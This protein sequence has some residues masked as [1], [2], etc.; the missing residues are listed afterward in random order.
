MRISKVRLSEKMIISRAVLFTQPSHISPYSN[1]IWIKFKDG[2]YLFISF[3]QPFPSSLT[4]QKLIGRGDALNCSEAKKDDLMQLSHRKSEI[5]IELENSK[6][7]KRNYI[8][9]I[10]EIIKLFETAPDDIY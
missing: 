6:N 3:E 4:I 7:S 2:Y 10:D 9:T 8:D 5:I 1:E